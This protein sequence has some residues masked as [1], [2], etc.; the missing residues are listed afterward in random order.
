MIEDTTAP[1]FVARFEIIAANNYYQSTRNDVIFNIIFE[2]HISASALKLQAANS[3]YSFEGSH[4]FF[5]CILSYRNLVRLPEW[6]KPS[7]IIFTNIF[8]R[9]FLNKM[10]PSSIE[11]LLRVDLQDASVRLNLHLALYLHQFILTT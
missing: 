2:N 9:H 11:E 1:S 8:I 7:A 4:H 3:G 10:H 5:F 6:N